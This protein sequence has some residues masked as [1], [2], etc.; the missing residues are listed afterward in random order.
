MRDSTALAA[1]IKATEARPRLANL[2]KP[3]AECVVFVR[4]DDPER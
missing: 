4:N 3:R 1:W 2:P